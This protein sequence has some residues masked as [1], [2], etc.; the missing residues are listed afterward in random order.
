MRQVA[1]A[2]GPIQKLVFHAPDFIRVGGD[3]EVHEM[4]LSPIERDVLAYIQ[5]K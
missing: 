5:L 3:D 2:R 4:R 1:T